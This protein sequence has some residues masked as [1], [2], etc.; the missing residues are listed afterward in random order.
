MI[1]GVARWLGFVALASGFLAADVWGVDKIPVF[2]SILPQ[3]YFVEQI[4]QDLVDVRTMVKPGSSPA[5]YEPKPDQMAALSR[6]RLYF[7]I[8]VPFENTWLGKLASFNPGMRIVRT[9]QEV[10]KKPIT[11]HEP[12][13]GKPAGDREPR[14]A[15][16]LDPHIWLSPPLVMIQARSIL[17]AL[18]EIDPARTQVYEVHYRTFIQRLVE[19]D[20]E[21]RRIFTGKSGLPFIVFH[22]AWGYFADAYG[23]RQVPVEVEGKEPKPAQLKTLIDTARALRIKVV[24]VQPQ[25]SARSAGQVAEA[26]GGQVVQADPLAPNWLENMREVAEKFKAAVQ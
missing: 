16:G 4:G 25:F 13:G 9:D 26:I 23:L 22:P 20:G 8:G 12:K 11:G 19:L 24:F 5:T 15:K 14:I 10:L 2:V 18:Q 3:K 7:S 6:A 1:I 21:L 17:K